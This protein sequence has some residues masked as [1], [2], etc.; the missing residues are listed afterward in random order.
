MVGLG[1]ML[2]H[3]LLT[4]LLLSTT[5]V[6]IRVHHLMMLDSSTAHTCH[7]RWSV[8]LVRTRSS[9]R[10][11]SRPVTVLLRTHSLLRVRLPLVTR[12]T[13]MLHWMRTPTLGIVALKS[14]TLC[15]NKKLDLHLRGGQLPPSFL[16]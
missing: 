1:Y 5:S 7:Y 8:R 11:V 9:T 12:L 4:L 14:Q 16:L 13:P 6:V 15:N 2:T 10:L 3:I